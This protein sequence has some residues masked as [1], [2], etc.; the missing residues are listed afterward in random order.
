MN[1]GANIAERVL[2]DKPTSTTP[3]YQPR[4][5][6]ETMKAL[7]WYGAQTVRVEEVPA[8]TITD[9]E[10]VVL[11]I[12]GATVCG[13]DLHLYH[14]EIIQLQEGDILGHEFCGIV[15]EVGP[16]VKNVKVGDRVVSSFQVACGTCHFCK[17]GLTSMCDTTNNS[18]LQEKMYGSKIGGVFGYSHFVGGFAGGQAEY[19][20]VPFG[21]NSLLK[22]PDD[23]PDE[24]A[25]YLSDIIPTSYHAV[26]CA[27]V[28]AGSVVAIWG[29]GP[30]GLFCAKWSLIQGASRV[31]CVDPDQQRIDFAVQHLGVE[32]ILADKSTDVVAKIREKIAIGPDC[33]IDAAGFRFTKGILHTVQRAVGLETD[34]SEILNEEIR[35]VRKFGTISLIADYAATTNGLNI[36]A[37]MEKGITLRG[38]G[39]CP[40]QKYWHDLLKKV[41]D[42]TFDP[43]FAITHRFRIEDTAAVYKMMDEHTDGI[44]KSFIQTKWSAPAAQ[45]FPVLQSPTV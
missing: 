24:K 23:V 18:N 4:A 32:G 28:Q 25:L 30:I 12:T 8:P 41:Q 3:K 35:A 9:P 42:G 16:A 11:R 5:S 14:K 43:T 19:V 37:I 7:R 1:L 40:V 20:R 17:Q 36:G 29:L 33:V 22:I 44:I 27:N 26:L 13:S 21:D 38:A 10:D 34:S 31:I 45:G 2:G 6:G 15:D 39:Q